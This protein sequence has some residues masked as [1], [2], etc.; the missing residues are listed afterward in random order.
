[1]SVTITI[2]DVPRDPEP[3]GKKVVASMHR[4]NPMGARCH[5][6]EYDD[7]A[8]RVEMRSPGREL[9][10][11]ENFEAGSEPAKAYKEAAFSSNQ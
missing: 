5:C 10:Y 2:L 6:F 3:K 4:M 8:V 11:A 1:M 9:L 7:G